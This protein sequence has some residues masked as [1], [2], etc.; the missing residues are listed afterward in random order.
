H[1]PP[2]DPPACPASV[3]LRQDTHG[4]Q[5]QRPQAHRGHRQRPSRHR[6]RQR[7]H[8]TLNPANQSPETIHQKPTKQPTIMIKIPTDAF[9]Q[10]GKLLKRLPFHRAKLPVFTHV[11]LFADAATQTATLVV[12]TLDMRLE[13]SLPLSEPLTQTVSFLIPLDAL[14]S[15]LK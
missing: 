5:Q 10:A 1:P 14:R 8:Q 13:T 12:A 9:K 6:R 15:A 3:Q 11:A 2:R 4:R 7:L